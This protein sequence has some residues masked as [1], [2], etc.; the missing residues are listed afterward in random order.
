M[1]NSMHL[2]IWFMPLLKEKLC[3]QKTDSLKIK[4][5]VDRLK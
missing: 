5:L 1:I 2:V 3:L 4:S